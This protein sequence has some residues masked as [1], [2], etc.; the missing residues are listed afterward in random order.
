MPF[1]GTLD[2]LWASFAGGELSPYLYARVDIAKFHV[3]AR[4]MSNF[5]VHPSGGASNRPGTIYVGAV[6][7]I[8]KRHRLIPFQFRTLPSGQT[9]ALVYGDTTMQVV[10][11]TG[12]TIGFVQ[13]P[14]AAITG[15]TKANPGVV[16]TG[17]AH[18]YSSG[19][20][21]PI[22]GVVGMTQVNG[23]TYTIT[24]LSPTTFSIGVD[25]SGYS[26]YTSGGTAGGG[27][28][29]L[30]SPYA[31]GDLP[32]LKFI[33]SADTMYL[34]HPSY[35]PR[36]LTRA[37][38]SAWTFATLLFVPQTS[39]PA[40]LTA[41]S[42]G[43]AAYLEVTA[44][45]DAT[46]EESLP[47][48]SVGSSSGTA[49]TWNWGSV[50]G[51]SNYNV[52]KKNGSVFGFVA[53]VQQATWTDNNLA[54]DVS[55]TPP[56][57]RN[58]F[59]PGSIQQ[60]V[61]SGGTSYTQ[62]DAVAISSATGSG[63]AGYVN[64]NGSGVPTSV[65]ITNPGSGYLTGDT[66]SITTGTGSGGTLALTIGPATGTYPGCTAFYMQRQFY[67]NTSNQPETMWGSN[68]GALT[69]MN[70]STPTEDSDAIT[71]TL[72]GQQVNEIRHLV[73]VGTSMM[74]LTSGAEWRCWPGATSSALTPGN[75]FVL[76][77]TTHGS[78]HVPPVFTENTLL[79]WQEKGS[80]LQ[81]LN[82]DVLQDIY[83]SKDQSVLAQHLL[84]D[85][86]G[87]Y[88]VQECAFAA[89]PFKILWSVRNDGTLLGFTYMK[90]HEVY[91]WHRHTTAG[92]V[93]SV[94][95]ITEPDGF[96]GYTDAVYLIV[97]R[98]ID[99]TAQ[100]YVER[101]SDRVFP[102]ISQA[103]FVDCGAQYNGWNADGSKTLAISG[104]SYAVG[105][106]VNVAAVGVSPSTS[107]YYTLVGADGLSVVIQ[108]ASSSTATIL[109]AAAPASVQ[110]IAT[111]DW[112]LMATSVS[113][114]SFLEGSTVA[115][116]GD[117]SVVPSQTVGSGAV[118]LDGPYA[119][120]TVGLPYTADLET[121]NLEVAEA[122]GVQGRMKKIA[123]VTVRVKDTRGIS[124][125]IKQ[126]VLQEVKQR[127]QETL[128]SPMQTFTGDFPVQVPSEWTLD[129]RVHVQQAYP[130]PC[131]VL[132]LFAETE[133]GAQ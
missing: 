54:G 110:N 94:C 114:L 11:N 132:G 122:G 64:V 128:G 107:Q 113:G 24:V 90:E 4:T 49:G 115:I 121:L 129:G 98:T 127:S 111:A 69:N 56:G 116:L 12:S 104:A 34:T 103:W 47:T 88:Q 19:T 89:V 71:R 130:L 26:S 57:A 84:S 118:T 65:T 29:T 63:F 109:V 41:T 5:L 61:P 106:T 9:Y 45:N 67:G 46:G 22:A 75:C 25:S 16:T 7:D 10:M 79:M 42:S 51:C 23:H 13:L 32:L 119:R 83:T 96:G 68:A 87:N 8:T 1:G 72:I 131:T 102:T 74:V 66:G 17:A 58:P 91:A 86:G 100:R 52:Y 39:A 82:Y 85:V 3:G 93:E 108:M 117:G 21:V 27:N 125:G 80:I 37:S 123:R 30:T 78:S 43:S 81:G 99:G 18:G 28:V 133:L 105:A 120:V 70:V 95:S 33:Q 126:S 59:A 6:D 124:V 15:I 101:M 76:P 60:I 38:H 2:A 77:Q 44:I 36:Q 35:A 50:A 31:Y 48:A 112:A 92:K 14:T 62:N 20:H 97:N 53:Q 55:I 40:G 73:P